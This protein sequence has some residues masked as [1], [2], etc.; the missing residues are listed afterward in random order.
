MWKF[1][2]FLRRDLRVPSHGSSGFEITLCF[3]HMCC[4]E[5]CVRP[6][7]PPHMRERI[8]LA[9]LAAFLTPNSKCLQE[10][11]SKRVS[12][13]FG[14][15]FLLRKAGTRRP[16]FEDPWMA[17]HAPP[18]PPPGWGWGPPPPDPWGAPPRWGPPPPG[19]G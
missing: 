1:C 11:I 5:Q 16:E 6:I 14:M 18:H 4:H 19:W 2:R 17:G 9:S 3:Q 7:A 12:K 10:G 15:V 8:S 13:G